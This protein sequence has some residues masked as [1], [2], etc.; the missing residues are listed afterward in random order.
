[1]FR[2]RFADVIRRQLDLFASE[3]ADLLQRCEDAERAYDRADRPDAEE[4]YGDYADLVD[5]G[6]EWLAELREHYASALSE[7]AAEEYEE[8]FN[9]AVLKRYRRFATRLDD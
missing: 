4:V 6:A 2:R 5:E 7:D 8:M 1:M 9:R 3:H